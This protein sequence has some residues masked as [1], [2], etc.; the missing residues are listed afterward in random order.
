VILV[1]A[2]LLLYAYNP[3]SSDHQAAKAWLEAALSSAEPVRFAWVTL[4][5][6]MRISTNSRAFEHPLTGTEA[7]AI[8]TSWLARPNTG[9]LEPGERHVELLTRLVAEGQAAGP[10]VMD[11]ALGAIATEHGATVY[12]TDRDFARFPGLKWRNPLEG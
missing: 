5:A 7:S 2:N 1:D 11:A 4:W 10:L 9:V 3:R 8:V 12:S 6:F